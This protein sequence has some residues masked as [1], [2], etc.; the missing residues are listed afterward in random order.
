[1]NNVETYWKTNPSEIWKDIDGYEGLYQ[2]SNLGRVFSFPRNGCYGGILKA[3]PDKDGYMKVT[4]QKQHKKK[5]FSVHR[6]VALAFIS[7]DDPI[8]K[9][10]VNHLD[11]DRANNCAENLEWVSP[12]RNRNYRR[13]Q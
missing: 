1:M 3:S 2:I 7:N 9:P 4:L 6:L 5:K 8:G 12:Q 11:F 13:I 10:L